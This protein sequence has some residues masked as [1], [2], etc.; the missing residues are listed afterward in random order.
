MEEPQLVCVSLSLPERIKALSHVVL[1]INELLKPE[2]I[3]AAVYNDCQYA[4]H[5]YGATRKWTAKAMDGAATRGRLDLVK[6]LSVVRNEGC[7]VAA[8]DGAARNGHLKVV[9]WLCHH[10]VGRCSSG[11]LN[12]AAK[13]GHFEVV[14]WLC[15]RNRPLTDPEPYVVTYGVQVV[16]ASGDTSTLRVLLR[17]NCSWYYVGRALEEAASKGLVDVVKLLLTVKLRQANVSRALKHAV[18][19]EHIEVVKLLADLCSSTELRAAYPNIMTGCNV[20]AAELLR[21]TVEGREVEEKWGYFRTQHKTLERMKASHDI[22]RN[23]DKS[24]SFCGLL[25]SW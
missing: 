12:M 2:T 1:R 11:A 7:T 25:R 18:A 5:K 22:T 3:D 20:K 16:A 9:K 17:E 24:V 10:Y 8:I 13:N 21:K 15:R 14:K 23:P 19:S 6:W 4:I